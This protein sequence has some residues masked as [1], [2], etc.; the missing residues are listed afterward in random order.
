[1]GLKTI[2]NPLLC[3]IVGSATPYHAISLCQLEPE[4][5]YKRGLAFA[6]RPSQPFITPSSTTLS[7]D[8]LLKNSPTF[9]KFH[10]LLSE[11][12]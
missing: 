8:L 10:S 1:M 7:L 3:G 11:N 12:H 5:E 9:N 6:T 4:V 2:G